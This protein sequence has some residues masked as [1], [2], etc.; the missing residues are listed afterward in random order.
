MGATA[1]ASTIRVLDSRAADARNEAAIA[2][3][4]ADEAMSESQRQAER[5]KKA[6]ETLAR[7]RA[8]CQQLQSPHLVHR[9]SVDSRLVLRRQRRRQ[10]LASQRR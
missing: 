9:C 10:H 2:R 3:S 4:Q 8:P 6:N 1:V 7:F 5:L